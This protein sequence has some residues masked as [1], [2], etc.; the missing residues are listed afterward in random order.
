[1]DADHER[2]QPRPRAAR[3]LRAPA[4]PLLSVHATHCPA[5]LG[6]RRHAPSPPPR[7]LAFRP[8]RALAS[9]PQLPPQTA[10]TALPAPAPNAVSNLRTP[11][12]RIPLSPRRQEV[13]VQSGRWRRTPQLSPKP[14]TI[15]HS[16]LL[17]LIGPA[18]IWTYWGSCGNDLEMIVGERRLSEAQSNGGPL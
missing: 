2:G 14:P 3:L 7:P 1:M 13:A 6:P 9:S 4:G 17:V 12:R 18:Q 15:L 16:A 8:S 11:R 10:G 5:P